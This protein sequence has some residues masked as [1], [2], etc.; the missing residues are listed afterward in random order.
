MEEINKK[1][2]RSLSSL[3]ENLATS[4][5]GKDDPINKELIQQIKQRND[6]IKTNDRLFEK[7]FVFCLCLLVFSIVGNFLLLDRND[8]MER[9]M[10]DS[11]W[12]DSLFNAIMEPDS[13]MVVR[14]G[15]HGDGKVVTYHQLEHQKDSISKKYEDERLKNRQTADSYVTRYEYEQLLL[16][17]DRLKDRI[18]VIKNTYHIR[19]V[20]LKDCYRLVSPEIDSAML[21]LPHYRNMLKYNPKERSWS[22]RIVK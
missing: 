8:Q 19:I 21:L 10:A 1:K 4:I 2:D 13:N 3:I 22:I 11:K 20:E 7:F 18:D 14:Y 12:K 15:V 9:E 17:N 16:E 6:E 5:N